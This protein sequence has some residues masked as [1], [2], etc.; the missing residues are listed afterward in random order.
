M[1]VVLVGVSATAQQEVL[2]SIPE[3]GKVLLGSSIICARLMEIGSP[4]IT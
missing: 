1:C 4:P 3:S 2:G